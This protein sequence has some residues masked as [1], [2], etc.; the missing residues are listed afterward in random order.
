MPNMHET[1]LLGAINVIESAPGFMDETTACGEAWQV[2][3]A[4][5]T[6]LQNALDPFQQNKKCNSPSKL[7]G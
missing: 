1:K 6:R 3:L 4:E 7:C 2:V 5:I